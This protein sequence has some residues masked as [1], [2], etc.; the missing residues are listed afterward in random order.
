MSEATLPSA[1]SAKPNPPFEYARYPSLKG[2]HVVVTGGG[3]SIGAALTEAFVVQ[4]ARVRFLDVADAPSQALAARLGQQAPS[5]HP[6]PKY[7]HCDL[8]RLDELAATFAGIQAEDGAVDVLVN[9]AASDARYTFGQLSAQDWDT[10]MAV[11]LRHMLFC[12]QAVVPG[13]RAA[14]G[15]V[16]LNLGSISWHLALP[17][18]VM[19]MAAKAGIEGMTRG[20]ARDLGRHLIRVNCIVPGSVV[21]PKYLQDW[22]T[23]ELEARILGEQCLQ[24]RVECADIAAMALFLASDQAARC[25]G[26]EYFV[27]A[28][29]FGAA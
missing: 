25:S 26:R 3:T 4:G 2:K 17:N 22:H 18:L 7:T 28:G 8:T 1:T 10:S 20:M 23:P 16:I 15:G 6:R 5:D 27:D 13:M 24:A 9:N 11:N 29:W 21:T 12:A 14:G 19:Y